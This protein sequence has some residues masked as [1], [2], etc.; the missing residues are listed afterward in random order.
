MI[1]SEGVF[2]LKSITIALQLSH[3]LGKKQSQHIANSLIFLFFERI[4]TDDLGSVWKCLGTG[5]GG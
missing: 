1:D 4:K 5:C 3:F 2:M